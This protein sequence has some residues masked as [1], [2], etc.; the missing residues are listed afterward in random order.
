MLH[1]GDNVIDNIFEHM[2]IVFD[3]SFVCQKDEAVELPLYLDKKYKL[4]NMDLLGYKSLLVRVDQQSTIDKMLKHIATINNSA[5]DRKIVLYFS[6]L[7]KNF[8]NV[9]I[10]NNIPFIVSDKQIF[11]PFVYVYL[12]NEFK[13]EKKIET[14]SPLTQLTFLYFLY[15][16]DSLD[17]TSYAKKIGYSKMST[18]RSLNELCEL[19]LIDFKFGGPNKRTKI[20][21]KI[22]RNYLKNGEEYL[23]SPILKKYYCS[24]DSEISVVGLKSGLNVLAEN[25]ML[26]YSHNCI[27]I[28]ENEF[29]E[30]QK[31]SELFSLLN[32][33]K[34]HDDDL[35]IEIWKYDPKILSS[36]KSVDIVSLSK[37]LDKEDVRVE[38]EL[39]Y[40]MENLY[41]V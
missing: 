41:E 25:S 32:T 20:Y 40:E 31:N 1:W 18:S 29:K 15:N 28:G 13:V 37:T 39:K 5:K 35:T 9:L 26:S 3:D 14:F 12:K 34:L 16:E 21:S 27:A 2:N 22:K 23:V 8:I 36:G 38:N 6:S 7:S 11:L 19:K 10:N 30:L 24:I 33:E 17:A 4:Y